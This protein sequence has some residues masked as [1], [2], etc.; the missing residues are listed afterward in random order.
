MSAKVA[1]AYNIQSAPL[2]EMLK[3]S[4]RAEWVCEKQIIS[5]MIDGLRI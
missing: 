3:R 4:L 2:D 5:A 1:A